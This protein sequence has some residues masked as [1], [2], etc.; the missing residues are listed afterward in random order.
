V[1]SSL[2]TAEEIWMRRTPSLAAAAAAVV[3][4]LGACSSGG[5]S[6]GASSR[7]SNGGGNSDKSGDDRGIYADFPLIP[8]A[9]EGAQPV[10]PRITADGAFSCMGHDDVPVEV[11]GEG[12][13]VGIAGT[14]KSLT[15]DGTGNTVELD[16][17]GAV[18]LNGSRNDV[19][20]VSGTGPVVLTGQ[21]HHVK[22]P[23]GSGAYPV[24]DSSVDSK[25]EG[26]WFKPPSPVPPP[27]VP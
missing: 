11:D 15:V 2:S 21:G 10:Q 25:I 5:G 12:L 27:T 20:V 7:S 17:A 6:H 9:G 18:T 4:V 3:L 22:L 8:I 23:A 14:C 26:S 24:Y 19:K 1:R 16:A 13:E